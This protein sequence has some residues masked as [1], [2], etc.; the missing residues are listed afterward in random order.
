MER[1]QHDRTEREEREKAEA[2]VA[3]AEAASALEAPTGTEANAK[4]ELKTQA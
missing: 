4:P 1:L 2:A 3:E